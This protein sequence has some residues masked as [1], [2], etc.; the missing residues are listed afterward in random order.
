MV[1]K[2]ILFIFLAVTVFFT[3]VAHASKVDRVVMFGDSL[4]DNGNLYA[5]TFHYVPKASGYFQG[6]FSN[7]LS[8]VERLAE[9]LDLNVTKRSELINYAYGGAWAEPSEFSKMWMPIP[10]LTTQ[11]NAYILLE[12][13]GADISHHLFVIWMGGNDYLGVGEAPEV[14]R[15]DPEFAT[16]NTVKYIENQTVALIKAGAKNILIMNMPDLSKTPYASYLK[17]AYAKNE[18]LLVRWHNQKLATMVRY[19]SKRYPNVKIVLFDVYYYVEEATSHPE[20]YNLTNVKQACFSGKYY[21]AA[22]DRTKELDLLNQ[23]GKGENL[24]PAL[25]DAYGVKGQETKCNNP[26]QYL[27]WDR[28]H[29]SAKMNK[30]LSEF[31]LRDLQKYGIA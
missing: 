14:G 27:Y 24:S 28:V 17:P 30:L 13:P 22:E 5:M 4:S 3:T 23:F 12:R 15:D 7:G 19:L 10:D 9:V 6:R 26:D 21:F 18:A 29:P 31:V 2:R 8:W 11:V 16:T 25:Q 20:K 1:F